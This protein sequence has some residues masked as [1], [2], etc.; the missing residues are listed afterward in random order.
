MLGCNII[1]IGAHIGDTSLP[2]AVVARGGTVV[3]FEMG[4]PF[5]IL[6]INAKLNPQFKID[7]YNLAITNHSKSVLYETGDKFVLKKIKLFFT[8]LY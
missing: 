3:A 8:P 7:V 4:T 1:D 2:L 5:E 6:K